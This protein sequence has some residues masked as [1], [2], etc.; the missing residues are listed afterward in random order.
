MNRKYSFGYPIFYE[1]PYTGPF[2]LFPFFENVY[3]PF[4]IIIAI[5][6]QGKIVHLSGKNVCSFLLCY[7]I[8]L[9]KNGRVFKSFW[10]RSK[11]RPLN[12]NKGEDFLKAR[13]LLAAFL[14]VLMTISV[15]VLPTQAAGHR[16]RSNWRVHEQYGA[17]QHLQRQRPGRDLHKG[18]N[19]VQG[20][21]AECFKGSD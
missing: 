7:V 6:K 16:R 21:G 14:C 8:I 2:V 19:D 5:K 10:V 18:R 1:K 4:F 15:M 9:S 11:T 20:M 12:C 17:L 13:K 3:M